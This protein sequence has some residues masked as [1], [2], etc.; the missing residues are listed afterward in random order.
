MCGVYFK[1]KLEKVYHGFPPPMKIKT[2]HTQL[3][4]SDPEE[5]K[6]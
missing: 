1:D 3:I 6:K 5:K 2:D 4:H